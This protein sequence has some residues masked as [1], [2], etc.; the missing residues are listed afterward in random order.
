MGIGGSLVRQR[1]CRRSANSSLRGHGGLRGLVALGRREDF[2]DR[3]RAVEDLSDAVLGQALE[4]AR[5][6]GLFADLHRALAFER[7]L[8]NPRVE[9]HQ[10][11]QAYPASVPLEAALATAH[12]AVDRP[13]LDV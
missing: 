8:A 10:L 9:F 3:R 7:R 12:R 2:L 11:E 1:C 13:T 4:A 5:Q 6:A